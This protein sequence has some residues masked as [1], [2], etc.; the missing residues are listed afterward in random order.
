MSVRTR[1]IHKIVDA[2]LHQLPA[3]AGHICILPPVTYVQV[4]RI[5]HVVQSHTEV[6]AE[7]RSECPPG[8]QDLRV[9]DHDADHDATKPG[10]A[11]P[12]ESRARPRRREP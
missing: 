10:H 2:A 1:N 11:P 3:E 12:R 9:H 6:R 7:E 4:T 5:V 8:S